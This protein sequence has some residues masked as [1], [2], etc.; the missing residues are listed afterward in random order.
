VGEILI[1]KWFYI[2]FQSALK[3][4]HNE[5]FFQCML[6]SPQNE[7]II[8]KLVSCLRTRLIDSSVSD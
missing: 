8:L 1:L 3:C 6:K 7:I 4:N 2:D 5:T